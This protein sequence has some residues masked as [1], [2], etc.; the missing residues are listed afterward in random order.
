MEV[1]LVVIVLIKTLT[2]AS[3]I[4][5][6]IT[7]GWSLDT[8]VACCRYDSKSWWEWTTFMAAPERTYDGRTRHG[9]PTSLQNSDASAKSVSSLHLRID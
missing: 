3:R 6:D 1:L 4:N 9:N 5:F 7:T 8:A 2:F